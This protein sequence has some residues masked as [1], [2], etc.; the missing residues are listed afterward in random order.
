MPKVGRLIGMIMR[1]DLLRAWVT[2]IDLERKQ[3]ALHGR[4]PLAWDRLLVGW[5]YESPLREVVVGLKFGRLEYLGAALGGDALPTRD[6]CRLGTLPDGVESDHDGWW[7]G[8]EVAFATD[9]LDPLSFPQLTPDSDV[10]PLPRLALDATTLVFSSTGVNRRWRDARRWTP[11]MSSPADA[12]IVDG[13]MPVAA[14]EACGSKSKSY[15]RK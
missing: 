6:E 5:V 7:D 12:W 11:A 3:L 8:E 4:A 2:R 13:E 9:P 10:A 1:I 15:G 14:S